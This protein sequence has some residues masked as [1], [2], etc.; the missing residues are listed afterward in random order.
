MRAEKSLMGIHHAIHYF[1]RG[2]EGLDE[3][4]HYINTHSP[5]LS[6]VRSGHTALNQGAVRDLG[7]HGFE[8]VSSSTEFT[9]TEYAGVRYLLF[10]DKVGYP[11]S[12]PNVRWRAIPIRCPIIILKIKGANLCRITLRFSK[13]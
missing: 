10:N 13:T 4:Y 11:S 1:D 8:M 5:S 6:F 9:S 12:G 2:R 7:I 3:P